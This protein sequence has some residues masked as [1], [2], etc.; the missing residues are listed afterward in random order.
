MKYK[1]NLVINKIL[2]L[3]KRKEQ[4]RKKEMKEELR[5]ERKRKS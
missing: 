2:E 4:R 3:E 5:M 1:T